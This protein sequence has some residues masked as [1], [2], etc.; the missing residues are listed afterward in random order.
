MTI[1]EKIFRA[2][3]DYDEVYEAGKQAEW[4]DFWDTFQDYGKRTEYTSRVFGENYWNDETFKPKYDLVLSL[5]SAMFQRS[6]IINLA[7][8]LAERNI[9]LDTSKSSSH[10]QM[11]QGANTK[12]IP[13]TDLSNSSNVNYTFGSNCKAETIDKLIVSETTPFATTTF[14][15]YLK[16]ITFEGVIGVDISFQNSS[17]TAESAKDVIM[18]LKDYSGTDKEFTCKVT[19]SSETKELLEAEGNTAP[20]GMAWLE[21]AQ[22]KGWNA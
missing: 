8:I 9:T 11:Y 4:S 2:K 6:N 3:T 12:H 22:A 16:H 10:L 20:N 21:Y 1:A 19:F 15:P 18:H 7:E 14:S 17:L 13:V 5:C